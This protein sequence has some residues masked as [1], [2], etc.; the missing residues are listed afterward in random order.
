MSGNELPKIRRLQISAGQWENRPVIVLQDPLG[1]TEQAVAV[2]REVA[3]L[4]ELCDGSRDI[5]TLRTAFELRT[6]L[7]VGPGYV[8]K[9]LTQ[10]D[11]ALLL[12]NERYMQAHRETVEK[13]RSAP[14]RPPR[15]AGKVY[16]STEEWLERNFKEYFEAAASEGDDVDGI[17]QVR[18]LVSPHIDY[19]RGGAVYARV[20]QRAAAA[21]SEAEVAVILGTNHHDCQKLFTVTRQSYSTPWG[22]MPTAGDVV[23]EVAA[24]LGDDEVF[25]EELHHRT[26]HSVEAAAVWL[27]YFVKD[28]A[29]EMVPVLCGSF[30]EFIHGDGHPGDDESIATFVDAVRRATANRRTLIVAAADLAHVGPAFGDPYPIDVTHKAGMSAADAELMDCIARGDAEGMFS[31]VKHEGDRRRICGLAP[32]YLA[33]RILGE[34]TGWVT[35][36]DHCPAD[37]QGTS[38]VSICGMVLS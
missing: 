28:S 23:D 20:W 17:G 30:H 31:K 37:Q 15:L 8:E 19:Q 18:G 35:G 21:A 38:F 1:L 2:P 32:I 4:I 3:P 6:G 33:L 10:L 36:Y 25:A 27:H 11:E 22:V 5:A 14:F 7:K 29:C 16:P 24:A 13:F 9:M 34:S 26:E 12:E